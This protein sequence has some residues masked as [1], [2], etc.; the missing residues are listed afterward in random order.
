MLRSQMLTP[1]PLFA[2]LSVLVLA[3]AT[4]SHAQ[5]PPSENRYDILGKMFRPLIPVLLMDAKEG[6][7]AMALRLVIRDVTGR[8]PKDFAGATLDAAVEFP[9]K[10]R[11]S[12]PV[13]GEQVTV[14]RNGDL[15]WATPGEK[16]QFL[17][18][19]F[20]SKLPAPTRKSNTPLFLPL[21]AQQ[22]VFLP[23]VFVLDDGKTFADLNGES[24]RLISGSLMPELAKATKS[25]D[26]RATVWVAA[27]YVPRQIL[28]ERRDFTITVGIESLTF[29]PALPAQ[30][31]QPPAGTTD[32]FRTNASVLEQVLFVVMN[33]I[34]PAAPKAQP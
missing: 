2:L 5:Q 19:Q 12:A 34:Q 14:C 6:D 27:G 11:L 3:A 1:R 17:L 21:T 10:V 31:W 7:R 16:V 9:D 8:L 26:F 29:S 4:Q 25:E 13:L 24:C 20:K 23:A 28:I 32:I 30:T 18:D 15:V 33:S 22:A